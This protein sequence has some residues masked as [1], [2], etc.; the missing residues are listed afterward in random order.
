M[1]IPGILSMPLFFA[2]S[3]SCSKTTT[4]ST[5]PKLPRPVVGPVAVKATP[6][7]LVF[8]FGNEYGH[9]FIRLSGEDWTPD[10]ASLAKP[11]LEHH[12]DV[13]AISRATTA[14]S[15]HS[16][17]QIDI[18]RD[19]VKACTRTIGPLSVLSRAYPHFGVREELGVS[20]E[21]GKVLLPK[22]EEILTQASHYLGAVFDDCGTRGE[23]YKNEF[24]WARPSSLGEPVIWTRLEDGAP[25]LKAL[26]GQ[27]FPLVMAMEF[28]LLAVEYTKTS[29]E[30]PLTVSNV[31]FRKPGSEEYL[32][33]DYRQ[34]GETACGGNGHE[35]WSLWMVVDGTPKLVASET[36]RLRILLVADLDN[37]GN[38][39]IVT[40]DGITGNERQLFRLRDG[41]LEK[42]KSDKYPFNDCIC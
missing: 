28:G 9:L 18:Y 27:V 20:N 35:L 41:K 34:I 3:I 21:Q 2:L 22:F 6:V 15:P 39:E 13:V 36:S 1:K 8:F 23:D 33:E 24:I 14:K 30:E 40:V 19:S 17:T 16:G 11:S 12:R 37:D 25:E 31:V 29:P 10:E 26:T 32:V 7:P 4:T 38:L 5:E 42:I